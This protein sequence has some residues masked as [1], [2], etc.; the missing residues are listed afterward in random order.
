LE[1]PNENI[2]KI[3]FLEAD[4][5]VSN[6]PIYS[7]KHPDHMYTSKLINAREITERLSVMAGSKSIDSLKFL[8]DV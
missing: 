2:F 4:A 7:Q 8:H 5:I 3:Q 1:D 6:L